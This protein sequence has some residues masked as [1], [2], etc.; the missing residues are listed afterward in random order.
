[1]PAAVHGLRSAAGLLS[2]LSADASLR[3]ATRADAGLLGRPTITES[4]MKPAV[5]QRRGLV[6]EPPAI[7]QF[8]L[9]GKEPMR[10]AC[11]YLQ[12][13]GLLV[14]ISALWLAGS[15][16]RAEEILP[17]NG[18]FLAP[19]AADAQLNAEAPKDKPADE[20]K[21]AEAEGGECGCAGY[22]YDFSKVP[23]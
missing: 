1:V 3:H 14:L 12:S 22:G 7:S 11:R 16:C 10:S 15:I 2:G 13:I 21:A 5:R 23:P 6:V 20:P 17:S 18:A 9:Q 19:N 8:E 4:I